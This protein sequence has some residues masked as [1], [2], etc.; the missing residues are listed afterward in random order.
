MAKYLI[1]ANYT[2][3]GLEG[4]LKDGGTKR[5][6]VVEKLA[7]SLGGKLEAFYYAFGDTD[8]YAIIDA[9]DNVS[10]ATASCGYR[11]VFQR[12]RHGRHCSHPA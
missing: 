10:A 11:G 3:K 8:L 9:P 12:N 1:K 4:L 2:Q 7:T 5:R 6:Q